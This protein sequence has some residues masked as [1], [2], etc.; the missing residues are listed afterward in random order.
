MI[1][2]KLQNNY[3]KQIKNLFKMILLNIQSEH[4]IRYFKQIKNLFK[5]ILLNIQ[6]E[7]SIRYFKQIKNL[8]KIILLNVQSEHSIHSGSP[9]QLIVLLLEIHLVPL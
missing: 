6:S 9:R 3:F 1:M 5:I 2:I 4:S 7:H 8:F